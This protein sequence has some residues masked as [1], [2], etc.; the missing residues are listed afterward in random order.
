V[1]LRRM[2]SVR[3]V[4]KGTLKS[5]VVRWRSSEP[6]SQAIHG[7]I[8][9]DV[10]PMDVCSAHGGAVEVKVSC[11]F[12]KRTRHVGVG[13]LTAMVLELDAAAFPVEMT[14]VGQTNCFTEVFGDAK[15]VNYVHPTA[16]EGAAGV[17]VLGEYSSVA[18]E[19]RSCREVWQCPMRIQRREEERVDR[20][21]G[22]TRV[23]VC[24]VY[25]FDETSDG[26][27]FCSA[28]HLHGGMKKH[29]GSM[30]VY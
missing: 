4:S 21:G 25:Y 23:V 17:T 13:Y 16:M 19:D 8:V 11:G 22:G 15:G 28:R 9:L 30:W 7:M 10:T 12:S 2:V 6:N 1:V 27:L 29:S 18:N 5:D 20:P 3:E 24:I 14:P 26:S